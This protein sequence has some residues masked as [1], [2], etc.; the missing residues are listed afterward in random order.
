MVD[1]SD[2]PMHNEG[3]GDGVSGGQ[4]A[5]GTVGGADEVNGDGDSSGVV[6]GVWGNRPRASEG[7]DKTATSTLEK[8]SGCEPTASLPWVSHWVAISTDCVRG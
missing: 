1:H 2:A 6:C 7:Q 5:D 3:P 4:V 8:D